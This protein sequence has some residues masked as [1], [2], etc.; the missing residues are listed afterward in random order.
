MAMPGQ[1]RAGE[2]R[3]G[4]V[5]GEARGTGKE[6]NMSPQAGISGDLDWD[7]VSRGGEKWSGFRGTLN[8][9]LTG[10]L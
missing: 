3:G 4:D 1:K 8:M 6:A 9:E 5:K 10:W 7:G 2:R